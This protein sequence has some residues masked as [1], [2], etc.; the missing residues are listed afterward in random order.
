MVTECLQGLE[1]AIA[2]EC[3]EAEHRLCVKHLHANWSKRFPGK[4]Y[5]DLMWEAA[6]ASNEPYHNQAMEKLKM[7][8][9]VAYEALKKIPKQKWTRCDFRKGSKCDMLVNNWAEAFNI[10]IMKAR[11]QPILTMLNTIHQIVMCRIV[12]E[13]SVKEKWG[14]IVCPRMERLIE[15]REKLTQKYCTR[16]AGGRNYEVST[17][18]HSFVLDVE[19]QECSCGLWDLSGMPCVHVVCVYTSEH[20][21]PRLF[22]DKSYLR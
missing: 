19:K 1:N 4:A 7:L 12:T 10:M 11:D 14:G 16:Y 18:D 9:Q 15:S 8:S 2:A 22:V 5:K 21:D 17:Q 20:K 3:P 6:R 13:N